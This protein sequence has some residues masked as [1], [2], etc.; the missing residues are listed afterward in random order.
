MSSLREKYLASCKTEIVTPNSVFQK[1]L[2]DDP[3][4]EFPSDTL[5]FTR[6]YVGDRG[7]VPVLQTLAHMPNICILKLKDNGLRNNAIHQ[8]EKILKD[9]PSLIEIDLS[10]NFIST[11]AANSLLRLLDE[12]QVI[13]KIDLEGTKIEPELRLKIGEKLKQ[14]A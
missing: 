1:M 10:H 11:G 8:L 9:H 12:N 3:D 4:T 5:D 7:V 6:N 2:P 13:R 14:R